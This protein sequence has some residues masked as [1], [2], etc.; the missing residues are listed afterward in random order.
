MAIK[1]G[2]FVIGRVKATESDKKGKLPF[3]QL[4][5]YEKSYGTATPQ[6]FD[7]AVAEYKS[8]PYICALKN[9]FS[10]A[11]C[12]LRLYKKVFNAEGQSELE[13]ITEHPFLDI[14]Q[15][16]NAF[17]NK[18][19]LWSQTG[20]HLDLT[21]NAYWWMPKD[22]LRT[23]GAIWHIPSHWM[24]VVPDKTEFIAGYVMTVPGLGTPVPFPVDEIVHFKF[25]P[26][27]DLFYGTGPMYAAAYG[28]DLN[29][30]IKT[31]GINYFMNN[32]QP[33]GV[34]Y[35]DEGMNNDAFQRLKD[36]WNRKHKGSENAGKIAILT[37]GLKYQQ[38]GSSLKDCKF[39]EVSREVRDE[40]LA[41]FGVPASKLGLVEDVN[42][43]NADANDYTYQKETVLPR[44]MLIEEKLNEKV[45]PMFDS[46]LVVKFDNPV[47][48][49]KE[50]RLREREI[51]IR[52]GFSSIDDE[53]IK[54]NL[55]PYDLP[56]TIVPLIPF[57]LTPA[58]TPKPE[59]D[60]NGLPISDETDDK[61]KPKKD[62]EDDKEDDEKDTE[63]SVVHKKKKDKWEL[64]ASITAPQERLFGEGMKR[65]FE[66]QRGEVMANLNKYRSYSKNLK[67]VTGMIIFNLNTEKQRLY[68]LS[69]A[70][71]RE[72]VISGVKLGI[73][74]TGAAIDFN[75]FEPNVLRSI[76]KRI[77]FFSGK[78]NESTQNLLAD[79]LKTAIE[80]GESID[81]LAQK[82][83]EIYNYSEKF[84]STRI[85]QTEVI[86]A[87]NDG[88]LMSYMEAGFPKKKWIT[89]RDE[90]VRVSHQIEGP[91]ISVTETFVT[92]DGNRLLY[93]GDRST[94]ADASDVI[95]C[96][97]TIIPVK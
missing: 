85:A 34:L 23:P 95:G 79:A 5:G 30:H 56:E 38:V 62:D 72:A 2:N 21:G 49:D 84:R 70:Y 89:A 74:E 81:T 7:R 54:D 47:P 48:E 14:M 42:R 13:E 80:K 22:S 33:S 61:D 97:C 68:G 75:L 32:A 39:E 37:N 86:G 15:N 53:R 94:G 51:N 43:A 46:G 83:G 67:D 45:M 69:K 66:A 78:I 27:F 55:E 88:Q 44:L 93:P 19:E 36:S 25:P 87:A 76:E 59:V 31:W 40:I 64:F 65:F 92:G 11:K 35:T 60:E 91:P 3:V 41:I 26:I 9:G 63:K 20:V 12:Q 4:F 10:I 58:G 16:V 6:D 82:V 90:K 57:S 1:I 50:F 17:H 28:V 24:R 8:W 77:D 73:D 29:K 18:F 52:S 71:I 96:R